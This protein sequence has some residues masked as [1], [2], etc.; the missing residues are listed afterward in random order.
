MTAEQVATIR[1]ILLDLTNSDPCIEEGTSWEGACSLCG[2]GEHLDPT[3]HW[4]SC[5]YRRARELLGAEAER[6]AP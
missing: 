5:P 1:A 3:G 2:A 6:K 4:P